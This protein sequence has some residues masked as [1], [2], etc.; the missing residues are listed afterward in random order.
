MKVVAK[1]TLRDGTVLV[2]ESIGIGKLTVNPETGTL[3]LDHTTDGGI[4]WLWINFNDEVYLVPE[5]S[6]S[7]IRLKFKRDEK[8][9][10]QT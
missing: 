4:R 3:A 10:D 8:D 6:V 7:L 5:T 9:E 2:A 1:I